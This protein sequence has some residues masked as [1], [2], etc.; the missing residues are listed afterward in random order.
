MIKINL[1]NKTSQQRSGL[2]SIFAGSDRSD[3]SDRCSLCVPPG[4]PGAVSELSD[5]AHDICPGLS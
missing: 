4:P 5:Q 3:R 2:I 1:Q